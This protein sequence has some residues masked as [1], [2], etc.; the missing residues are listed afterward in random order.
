MT[1]RQ[2]VELAARGKDR[3]AHGTSVVGPDDAVVPLSSSEMEALR[4]VGVDPVPVLL[5]QFIQS[6]RPTVELAN[7]PGIEALAGQFRTELTSAQ[8]VAFFA[9]PQ[10][11][12]E[13]DEGRPMN[14]A[15]WLDA[16]R[17]PRDVAELA[18]GL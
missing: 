4:S 16:G 5:A 3:A 15:A 7:I 14:P 1:K 6:Q 9:V 11:D 2:S 13:D 8:I 12:L 10:P 18:R 17:D